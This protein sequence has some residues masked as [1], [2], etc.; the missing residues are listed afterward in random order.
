MT[1]AFCRGFLLLFICSD[2]LLT[3][4]ETLTSS[5]LTACRED[6]KVQMLECSACFTSTIKKSDE[7]VL[8]LQECDKASGRLHIEDKWAFRNFDLAHK[9]PGLQAVSHPLQKDT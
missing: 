4:V 6:C 7:L 8:S 3:D 1:F 2:L 9:K 5:S